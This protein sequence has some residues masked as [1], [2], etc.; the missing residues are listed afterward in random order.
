M[1]FCGSAASRGQGFAAALLIHFSNLRRGRGHLR[2]VRTRLNDAV[3]SEIKVC[4]RISLFNSSAER[5]EGECDLGAVGVITA[6]GPFPTQIYYCAA[7]I[8]NI[9]AFT[10]LLPKLL[11]CLWF[12]SLD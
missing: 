9:C 12:S 10:F 8:L 4:S 11:V 3:G 1:S 6:L 7:A 2:R 5:R